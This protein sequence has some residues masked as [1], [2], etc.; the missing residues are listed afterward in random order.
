MF[1]L[2]SAIQRKAWTQARKLS[3]DVILCD[4]RRK[5][6][7][8]LYERIDQIVKIMDQR[9]RPRQILSRTITESSNNSDQNSTNQQ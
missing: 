7:I 4:P 2:F 5:S 3:Y 1:D 6:Y 9:R 8:Q